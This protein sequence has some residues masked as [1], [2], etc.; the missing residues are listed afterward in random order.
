MIN[1]KNQSIKDN[2]YGVWR[3]DQLIFATFLQTFCGFLAISIYSYI[4]NI[5]SPIPI[6]PSAGSFIPQNASQNLMGS[7]GGIISHY[8]FNDICGVSAFLTPLIPFTVGLKLFFPKGRFQLLKPLITILFLIA[9]P[10]LAISYWHV[11]SQNTQAAWYYFP[12]N[13]SFA[14]I[15]ALNKLIG[16]GVV[17][18][19]LTLLVSIIIIHCGTSFPSPKRLTTKALKKETKKPLPQDSKEAQTAQHN[20][21]KAANNQQS[22]PEKNTTQKEEEGLTIEKLATHTAQDLKEVG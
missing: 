12:G 2:S 4:Q 18:L 19:L 22:P 14:V 17:L 11:F 3:R 13:K 7:I 8:L 9:W 5:S 6:L 15:T 20:S 1:S 10:S 16:F 21:N